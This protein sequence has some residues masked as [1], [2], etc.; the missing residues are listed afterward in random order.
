MC[1]E[2]DLSHPK[3]PKILTYESA[4]QLFLTDAHLKQ[5]IDIYEQIVTIKKKEGDGLTNSSKFS[6]FDTVADFS[7]VTNKIE[8]GKRFIL[9]P[10]SLVCLF[11]IVC[12]IIGRYRAT[13]LFFND[14]NYVIETNLVKKMMR[15]I[16]GG[17]RDLKHRIQDDYSAL[18]D[19]LKDEILPK[20]E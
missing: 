14:L 19:Y 4:F 16:P 20:I 15:F 8:A 18:K 12:I 13:S 3:V 6:S 9:L 1:L 11:I 5:L 7:V 17:Y 10:L 2:S